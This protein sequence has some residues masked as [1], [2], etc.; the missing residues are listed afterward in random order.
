VQVTA[1]QIISTVDLINGDLQYQGNQD[2]NG[3]DS[4]TWSGSDGVTFAEPAN[5]NISILPVNDAPGLDVGSDD[6]GQEAFSAGS[7]FSHVIDFSDPDGD[8]LL[9]EVN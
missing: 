4:F 9:V 3:L 8:S 5:T 6:V 7:S 2:F 1:G